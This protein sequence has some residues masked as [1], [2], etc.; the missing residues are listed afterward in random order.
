VVTSPVMTLLIDHVPITLLC[1]LVS[2]ADVGSTA[3]NR[4]ERPAWDPIR[5]ELAEYARHARAAWADAQT[6]AD[7][8][9]AA[10]A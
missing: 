2:L 9:T 7:G 10:S 4:A 6:Q 3:I 8:A 1:D 5:D